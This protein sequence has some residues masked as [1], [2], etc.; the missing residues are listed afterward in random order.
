[1]E[2]LAPSVA[3]SLKNKLIRKRAGEMETNIERALTGGRASVLSNFDTATS[4]SKSVHRL[5]IVKQLELLGYCSRLPERIHCL[6]E[7]QCVDDHS[8]KV[9]NNF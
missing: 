6:E 2:R 8:L 4:P 3:S 5:Q 7:L 1:M 9:R